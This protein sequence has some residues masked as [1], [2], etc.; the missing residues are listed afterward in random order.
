MQFKESVKLAA[1]QYVG[2]YPIFADKNEMQNNNGEAK[3]EKQAN[4]V[5]DIIEGMFDDYVVK[6][7]QGQKLLNSTYRVSSYRSQIVDNVKDIAYNEWSCLSFDFYSVNIRQGSI[8]PVLRLNIKSIL[9]EIIFIGVDNE[10]TPTASL[11][12]Y[13]QFMLSHNDIMD[14]HQLS[15]YAYTDVPEKV[16][17]CSLQMIVGERL[18]G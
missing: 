3:A 10:T 7:T 1:P 14:E 5:N 12:S 16:W 13:G 11:G 8:T 17:H 4:K 15:F 9:G 6:T 2:A 18:N